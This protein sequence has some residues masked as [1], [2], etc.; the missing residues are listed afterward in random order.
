MGKPM[1]EWAN[2]LAAR[3]SA[4]SAIDDLSNAAWESASNVEN[5][6]HILVSIDTDTGDTRFLV[7]S[8]SRGF[9]TVDC[10]VRRAS[11]VEPA[12]LPLRVL[13]T[14]ARGIFG[15]EGRIAAWTRVWPCKW[16]VNL[17][18]VNGPIIP[19]EWASRESAIQFE[20]EWLERYFL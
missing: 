18:P 14:L 5:Q 20:V 11:H 12:F 15:D 9:L 8:A 10:A 17:S 3:V 2:H 19:V 13:F 7:S 6:K 16:R 1:I 4:Q